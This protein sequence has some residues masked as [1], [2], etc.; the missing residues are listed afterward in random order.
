MFSVVGQYLQVLELGP[1]SNKAGPNLLLI[2]GVQQSPAWF[3]QWFKKSILI[4]VVQRYFWLDPATP[5]IGSKVTL[6]CWKKLDL[7]LM[8]LL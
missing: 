2:H 5:L 3:L 1:R 4:T 8:V 7:T 6:G